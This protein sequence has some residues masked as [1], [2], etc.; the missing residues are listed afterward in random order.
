[1]SE[2]NRFLESG[3]RPGSQ[4]LESTDS[5]GSM[6]GVGGKKKAQTSPKCMQ[7]L[8]GNFFLLEKES[9]TFFRT[10]EGII[11]FKIGK[12]IGKESRLVWLGV[13]AGRNQK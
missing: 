13:A 11:T 9:R 6:D 7:T 5:L 2:E 12:S 10:C 1:M 4:N 3:N 8:I